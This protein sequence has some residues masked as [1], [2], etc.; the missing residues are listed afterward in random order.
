MI[1][2][3]GVRFA[4][5]LSLPCDP[6]FPA[7]ECIIEMTIG[8]IIHTHNNH[9]LLNKV[10]WCESFGCKFLG[11]MLRRALPEDEG[12]LL[13]GTH[14]SRS[15][16]AI[17]MLFMLFPI[18]VIWLDNEFRVVDKVF[19]RPWRL[20]YIPAQPARYTLEAHPDLLDKIE[21]GDLLNFEAAT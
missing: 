4:P 8:R 20:A 10:R 11:L 5:L 3:K 2:S 16:A 17:H 9:V 7:I 14:A 1:T 19:A 12:L 15:A 13:V 21:V 6:G 18:T